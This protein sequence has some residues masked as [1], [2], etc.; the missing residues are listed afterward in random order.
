MSAVFHTGGNI[1]HTETLQNG[2]QVPVSDSIRFGQDAL[3]LAEFFAARTGSVLDLGAGCG[4]LDFLLID[5]GFSGVVTALDID[6]DACALVRQGIELN[7]LTNISVVQADLRGYTAAK[8]QDAVLC[9]PPYFPLGQGALSDTAR[10]Q[11][12]RHETACTIDDIAAAAA[13]NLKQGGTFT[14]C[15]R[16]ERLADIFYVL[17]HHRLEPKRLQL[18]RHDTASLPWLALIESR[19]DGGTGLDILP[20]KIG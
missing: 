20:D 10:N 3:L 4:I 1:L 8:K 5:R 18:V 7:Q 15:Y 11:T 16:P 6:A 13:R 19:Y 2:T 12:A 17:R 9:N 14:C